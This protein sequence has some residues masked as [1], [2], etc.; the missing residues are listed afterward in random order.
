MLKIDSKLIA[1]NLIQAY[2]PAIESSN[3]EVELL[4]DQLSSLMKTLKLHEFNV[5]MGNFNASLGRGT[6]DI[7]GPF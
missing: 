7:V 4:Y 3:D 5:I 6:V 1:M 2:V